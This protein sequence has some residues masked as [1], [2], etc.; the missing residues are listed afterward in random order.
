M[1][2]TAIFSQKVFV[3]SLHSQSGF[4][5]IGT[6]ICKVFGDEG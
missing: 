3:V 4:I 6:V 1:N 5:V 2:L